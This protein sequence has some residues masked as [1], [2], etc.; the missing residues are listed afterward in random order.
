MDIRTLCSPKL[1][2]AG[3]CCAAAPSRPGSRWDPLA[4]RLR[5][6]L[7]GDRP[8]GVDF[9]DNEGPRRHK[10]WLG[11]N[12]ST[13]WSTA[14]WLS[15]GGG[16]LPPPR[17]HGWRE[18]WAHAFPG[19]RLDA[20]LAAALATKMGRFVER[21]DPARPA[22]TRSPPAPVTH[23]DF[24]GAK[25]YAAWAGAR[26][27]PRWSGNT[28]TQGLTVASLAC[29]I[30]RSGPPPPPGATCADVRRSLGMVPSACTL[31]GV[32]ARRRRGRRVQRQVH[33]QPVR[34]AG[35]GLRHAHRSRP[36]QLPQLLLSATAL[37]VLR[38]APGPR[39]GPG[40]RAPT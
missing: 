21:H 20:I 24:T 30:W 28:P 19:R 39:R 18:G 3:R 34:L 6:R 29:W 40:L 33:G 31:S 7:G 17:R 10:V 1:A 38:R 26:L 15:P 13:G 16:E 25:A 2:A 36:R 5:G 23:V 8:R 9:A 22:P 35:R 14:E 4:R 12:C 37:D 27:R 32:Q 11:T